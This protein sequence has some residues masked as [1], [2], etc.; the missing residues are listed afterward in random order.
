VYTIDSLLESEINSRRGVFP[1]YFPNQESIYLSLGSS[2]F[3]RACYSIDTQELYISDLV[4]IPSE[5]YKNFSPLEISTLLYSAINKILRWAQDQDL[6]IKTMRF[7]YNPILQKDHMVE[8]FLQRYFGA[9]TTEG[10]GE[11]R[12]VPITNIAEKLH[13]GE[14]TLQRLLETTERSSELRLPTVDQRE[15]LR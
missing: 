5:T 10:I 12:V 11:S 14:N 6:E 9:D 1:E 8:T 4:G 2:A 3:A 7:R 13:Q 15:P